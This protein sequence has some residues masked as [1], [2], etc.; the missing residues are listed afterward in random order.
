MQLLIAI[1]GGIVAG[2]VATGVTIWVLSRHEMFDVPNERSSHTRPTL[3]GGGFGLAAGALVALAIAHTGFFG[4]SEI[5]V[6]IAGVGFGAIGFA[7]DLAGGLPVPLRLSLQL[8]AAIIV[9]AVV[10]EHTS[11]GVIPSALLGAVAVLWIVSFVNAFNFMDGINGISCAEAIVAGTAFGLL[12][13]HEHRLRYRPRRLPWWRVRSVSP[14]STSRPR[15]CSSVTWGATSPVH[16]WPC[17]S[18]SAYGPRSGRGDAGPGCA[19]RS[20]YRRRPGASDTPARS[21]ASGAS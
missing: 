18:S 21:L 4:A 17:W 20:G 15:G 19:L 1:V 8:V 3:R 6:I 9:T 12:A 10:W 5:A 11:H 14:P 2:F 13:R 16:G 7:D